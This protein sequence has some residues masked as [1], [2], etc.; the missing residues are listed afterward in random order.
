VTPVVVG[1]VVAIVV[2]TTVV[3][4]TVVVGAAVVATTVVA[5]VAVID[6]VTIVAVIDVVAVSTCR[7]KV[8]PNGMQMAAAAR[9]LMAIPQ[10]IQNSLCLFLLF[11]LG[12]SSH[13]DTCIVS[14]SF[15]F[16][17]FNH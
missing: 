9:T 10:I 7:A 16:G 8:T 12:S 13:A 2:V 3:V 5:I 4:A 1:T 11:S 15:Q 17:F 6:V 14:V